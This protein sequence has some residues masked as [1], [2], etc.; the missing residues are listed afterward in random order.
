MGLE[1]PGK[2]GLRNLNGIQRET[3]CHESEGIARVRS[4]VARRE[5]FCFV[6]TKEVLVLRHCLNIVS[7]WLEFVD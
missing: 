1:L 2:L 4:R 3:S 6:L 7:A 5:W